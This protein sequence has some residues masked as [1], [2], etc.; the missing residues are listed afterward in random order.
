[1]GGGAPNVPIDPVHRPP[2]PISARE[3]AR[4]RRRSATIVGIAIVVAVALVGA[5][6][7]VHPLG[8]SAGASCSLPP[9]RQ[10]PHGAWFDLAACPATTAIG[11][12]S[13][14][15]W[16]IGRLSDAE[17]V[18]GAFSANVTVGVYMLNETELAQLQSNPHPTGPPPAWLWSGGAVA[19]ARL[20][21]SVP[22]SP[23][24]PYI[25]IE[26]LHGGPASVQ[27]TKT[28]AIYYEA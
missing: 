17:A 13:Y 15:V 11:A 27:W 8:G 21:V 12:D 19:S 25:V 16:Q 2:P 6:F 3:E 23:V 4:R 20:N 9:P 24:Q 22:P 14:S 18:V 5:Y 28:L 26:N 10:Y 1:M 7:A